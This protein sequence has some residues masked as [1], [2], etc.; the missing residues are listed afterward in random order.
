MTTQEL[1]GDQSEQNIITITT[2]ELT[3]YQFRTEFTQYPLTNKP[4]QSL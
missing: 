1:T 2:Q 4:E 3:G